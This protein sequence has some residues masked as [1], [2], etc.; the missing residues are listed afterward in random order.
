MTSDAKVEISYGF[1]ESPGA[2]FA[3]TLLLK[4]LADPVLG[5]GRW[6]IDNIAYATGGDLRTAL[7]AA[8]DG[9]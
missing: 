7:A 3:E 9:M 2:D 4:R 8:F 5:L 6:R 1:P